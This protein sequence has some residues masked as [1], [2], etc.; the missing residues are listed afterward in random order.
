MGNQTE[1][2][3]VLAGGIISLILMLGIARFAYTPLLPI[4]LEQAGLGLSQ[5]G[6][7]TAVNY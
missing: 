1:R 6:W 2:L 4:M 5:G 3:K 7:L